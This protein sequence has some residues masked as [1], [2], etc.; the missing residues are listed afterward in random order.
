MLDRTRYWILVT[1]YWI[2]KE[3]FS[4][5][6]FYPGS[7]IQHPES[8]TLWQP[9][10]NE[11]KNLFGSGLSGL[12]I[13]KDLCCNNNGECVR[14]FQIS[15][16]V[17]WKEPYVWLSPAGL[18]LHIDNGPERT[19]GNDNLIVGWLSGSQFLYPWPTQD[20]PPNEGFPMYGLHKRVF[21]TFWVDRS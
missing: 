15:P 12:D 19:Q 13:S 8:L 10:W 6:L 1:G 18:F 20:S 5:C 21:V 11:I 14:D 4:F 3:L 9:M 16:W 17:E 7:S 2:L